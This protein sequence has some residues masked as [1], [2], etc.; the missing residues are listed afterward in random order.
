M[1]AGALYDEIG[2]GYSS[3]RRPDPCIATL[4]VE[5]LAEACSVVSVGAGAGSY[6][7]ADRQ[8]VA[9]EPSQVMISQRRPEAPPVVQAVAEALPLRDGSFDAAMAIF[10]IHHWDD[11]LAGLAEMRRVATRQVV[12]TFDPVLH[13]THWICDYVP[14][15]SERFSVA[16]PVERVAEALGDGRILPVPLAHDTPDGMTVAYWRRPEAYLDPT[17]RAGGSAFRQVDQ[18]ALRQGLVRLQ[19]DLATG[20]WKERYGY[21]LGLDEV[22]YGLRLIAN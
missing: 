13:R 17:L 4:I 21:L 19:E 7:P 18:E 5:A 11:V 20:A 9:V 16:P 15:I 14:E 2:I 6:E 22:D 12:L 10:T 1:R 3:Q 8:V